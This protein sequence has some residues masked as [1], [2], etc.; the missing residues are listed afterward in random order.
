MKDHEEVVLRKRCL[1]SDGRGKVAQRTMKGVSDKQRLA[2]F[3]N[4]GV[5]GL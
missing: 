3:T 4:R 1:L 2:S 5:E